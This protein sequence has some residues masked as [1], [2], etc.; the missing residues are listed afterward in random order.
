MVVSV[1]VT[2]HIC[3]EPYV[4]FLYSRF[5]IPW[6]FSY[7]MV[8]YPYKYVVT[9]KFTIVQCY[10]TL[11]VILGLH[12]CNN[13]ILYYFCWCYEFHRKYEWYLN[14][15]FCIEI[16]FICPNDAAIG[17]YNIK[18]YSV[19]TNKNRYG[20]IG[21]VVARSLNFLIDKS[22]LHSNLTS[23]KRNSEFILDWSNEKIP[24]KQT[25]L[26]EKVQTIIH[27]WHYK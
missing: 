1:Y 13:A 24:L 6:H 21:I 5:M 19:I 20:N 2:L 10:V 8:G 12:I 15:F 23:F 7:D 11:Y 25:A 16:N 3:G 26:I 14:I 9:L 22:S 18:L 27:K 17:S 4:P